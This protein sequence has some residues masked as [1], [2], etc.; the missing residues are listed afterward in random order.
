MPK[1]S[2]VPQNGCVLNIS[3]DENKT[4][5]DFSETGH[6][7]FASVSS[8]WSSSSSSSSSSSVAKESSSSS[9]SSFHSSSS[10]FKSDNRWFVLPKKSLWKRVSEEEEK[11]ME[12]VEERKEIVVVDKD[13]RIERKGRC[14]MNE[15]N[16]KKKKKGRVSGLVRNAMEEKLSEVFVVDESEIEEEEK[17][18]SYN[19]RFSLETL[20]S[21]SSDTY[22]SSD[23]SVELAFKIPTF[24]QLN[25]NSMESQNR[26]ND[27]L[28]LDN[29]PPLLRSISSMSSSSSSPSSSQT[30]TADMSD[31]E[32]QQ[33]MKEKQRECSPRRC[34][35]L[36]LLRTMTEEQLNE[37]D[38]AGP[39]YS[40]NTLR[41]HEYVED[42]YITYCNMRGIPAFPLDTRNASEES[43]S[44]VLREGRLNK[45]VKKDGIGKEHFLM[46][47]VERVISNSNDQH[48]LKALESSLWLVTISTGARAVS[49]ENVQLRDIGAHINSE[50][51]ETLILKINFR[52]TKGNP[53]RNH[54]ISLEGT[55]DD[56]ADTNVLFWLN[57]HLIQI[58]SLD[59]L[60]RNSLVLSE[61]MRTRKLWNLSR[62]AMS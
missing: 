48:P 56:R 4:I 51:G 58:F 49:I 61:G 16:E 60:E 9:L 12:G 40:E 32:K 1:F 57:Q 14:G 33:S 15:R 25:G 47:K 46:I 20:S 22:D 3:S 23:S 2:S 44:K 35:A 10:P 52:V 55:L 53:H 36:D 43:I 11:C 26:E 45:T 17:D 30:V 54:T 37:M 29:H 39:I 7:L 18:D 5:Q 50:S 62:D 8:S 13:E 38:V 41:K 27:F 28:G 21:D 31:W 24:T 34:R 19:Q 6:S 42:I 59:L